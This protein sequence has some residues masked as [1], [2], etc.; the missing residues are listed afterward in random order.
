MTWQRLELGANHLRQHRITSLQLC[1]NLKISLKE[2]TSAAK[3]L[4]SLHPVR[5]CSQAA[6]V[7]GGVGEKLL[8]K[9]LVLF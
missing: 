2:S 3:H 1:L 6:E 4:L 8:D 7:A 5:Y 9:R